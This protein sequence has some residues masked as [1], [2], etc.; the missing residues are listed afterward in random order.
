MQGPAR[1]LLERQ[2][3]AIRLLQ[4]SVA[5]ETIAL[6]R[7]RNDG[8]VSDEIGDIF[9]CIFRTSQAEPL[10]RAVFGGL[11]RQVDA[12][13]SRIIGVNAREFTQDLDRYRYA[14]VGLIKRA[15]V[16]QAAKL[17]RILERNQGL[18]VSD[19]V[20][21]IQE[22]TDVDQSRAL[23]WARDQTTK[24]YSAVTEE[25]HTSLGIE[26]YVW[27]TAND[28]IVRGDPNGKWP[29]RNGKGGDHYSLNGRTFR[30]DDPPVVDHT[31]RTANPGRDY[32]C[33]CIAYPVT[34]AAA[35][36]SS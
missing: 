6:L 15:T 26:E 5:K 14:F 4:A 35:S 18:H 33:R 36:L 28:E 32:V 29:L 8:I 27:T 22:Q 20:R 17:D 24:L 7:S 21:L 31:G 3:E 12:E 1:L 16:Q 25:R 23:L 10:M 13:Q 2:A 30:Y 9:A 11:V 19:L 34:A